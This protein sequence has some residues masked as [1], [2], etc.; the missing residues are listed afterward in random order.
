MFIDTGYES[1][2][3]TSK[4]TKVGVVLAWRKQEWTLEQS[5]IVLF[6]DLPRAKQSGYFRKGM[7]GII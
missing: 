7:L 4:T 1:L 5:E 3:E 2:F 6:E